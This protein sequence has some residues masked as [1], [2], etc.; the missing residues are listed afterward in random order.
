[1]KKRE[2]RMKDLPFPK[3]YFWSYSHAW[4]RV[5][6]P[7]SLIMEQLIRYGSFKDHISLF[8]V[9]PYKELKDV[10]CNKI[11]P[12]MSGEITPRPGMVPT[13]GDLRNVKYMDFL[14]E[15]LKDVA[16]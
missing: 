9:F 13:K 8:V 15:V 10:Y 12:V 1:M 11:R 4:E 16:P 6:L 3:M 5:S 14:F 7:L 2:Y